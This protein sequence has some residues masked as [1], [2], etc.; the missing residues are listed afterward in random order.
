MSVITYYHCSQCGDKYLNINDAQGC[1]NS[2]KKQISK[3]D[4]WDAVKRVQAAEQFNHVLLDRIRWS[5]NS[6]IC[7]VSLAQQL[8]FK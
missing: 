7:A 3:T 1:D 2:H 5:D 8:G 6:K 4:F